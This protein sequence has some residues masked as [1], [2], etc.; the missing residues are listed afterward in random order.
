M[1]WAGLGW[2]GLLWVCV[3]GGKYVPKVLSI[4]L[5]C[6]VLPYLPRHAM[7]CHATPTYLGARPGKEQAVKGGI[8]LDGW[9]QWIMVWLV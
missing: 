9:V 5:S 1:P 2:A 3:G 4:T 7:P 6:L 8:G